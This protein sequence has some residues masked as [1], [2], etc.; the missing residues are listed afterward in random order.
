MATGLGLIA[1]IPAVVM[2]NIFNTSIS[3]YGIR[4]EQFVSELIN[5]LSR[6]LDK[7]A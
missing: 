5:S 4:S 6:Q 7:G 2:Y 1:A 3:N